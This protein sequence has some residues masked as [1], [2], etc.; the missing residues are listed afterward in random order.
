MNIIESQNQGILEIMGEGQ[1][2]ESVEDTHPD[3]FMDGAASKILDTAIRLSAP[4]GIRPRVAIEGAVKGNDP[5]RVADTFP[6]G[7]ILLVGEVTLPD[8]VTLDYDRIVRDAIR[9]RGYTD[10]TIG[11][12]ADNVQ[13]LTKITEQSSNINNGV[14]KKNG[15]LA[16][17]DQ[18]VAVGAAIA[19]E[20]PDYMPHAV[21]LANDLTRRLTE[22]KK[23]N[24]VDGLKPDGK[25]QVTLR[26]RDGKF[27]NVHSITM[28]TAH[29][30]KLDLPSVE[31]G[32]LQEVIYPVFDRHNIPIA[33]ETKIVVNGAGEWYKYGPPADAGEVGRKLAV[34]FLSALY[35]LGGGTPFGKDPSKVDLTGA[36]MGRFG[37]R[38]IVENGLADRAQIT[39]YWTIGR[40]KPDFI[41]VQLFDTE[42]YPK[43]EIY[44][45]LFRNIAFTVSGAIE[46]LK[47]W[48]V[49]Y[50]PLAAGGIFGRPEY[51]W[52]QVPRI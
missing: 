3:G 38:F 23:K 11:F 36:L 45:H 32:M 52:E 48:D 12:C 37:S 22:V 14:T 18:G 6:D 44:G 31:R 43:E 4:T 8:G 19:G 34:A 27:E 30:Q 15:V 47:L 5:E 2:A 42:H 1:G 16:A 41:D 10:P 17:G 20:A 21:S 29:D 39:T 35:P 28:A 7:V 46:Q 49:I 50:E 9:E 40:E 13:I 24:I 33:P 51:P 25:S 26:Y